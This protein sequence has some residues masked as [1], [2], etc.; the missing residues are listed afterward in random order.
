MGDHPRHQLDELLCHGVRLSVL[1]ALDG[2]E[3]VEF[4]VVRDGVQVSDSVLSKQVALLEQA[5][6]V[7][8]EKG[9]VGRR[10]RTWLAA[11]PEG[12]VALRSHLRAVRDVAT[13]DISAQI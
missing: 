6:Y 3:R 5:G 4:A 8:V 13:H 11:T 9:R 12:S 1:A 10:A 7:A 2:P